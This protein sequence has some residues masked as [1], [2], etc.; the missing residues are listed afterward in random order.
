MQDDPR[1]PAPPESSVQ[2]SVP[3]SSEG[4]D[5]PFARIVGVLFS[6]EE[7]FASIARRPDWLVPLLLMII[8]AVGS[9]AVLAPKIDYEPQF[10]AM[11]ENNRN[12]PPEQREKL[13]EESLGRVE[14]MKVFGYVTPV[15]SILVITLVMAGVFWGGLRAFGGDNSFKQTYAVTVYGWIPMFLKSVI[16]TLIA[17]P[18][19]VIDARDLGS[20]LKSNLGAFVDSS[21]AP[22]LNSLL[23]S[24]DLFNIWTIVL[25]TIGLAAI[26]RFNRTNLA[27]YVTALYLIVV[28][29]KVGFAALI[30]GMG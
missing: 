15:L 29:V 2:P 17:L 16:S 30:G 25:F 27:I 3:S 9:F 10:R 19:S 4:Q 8:V 6:P 26:S 11:F 12:I 24:V 7:T 28:A 20:L 1:A 22:V 18:R 13:I 14:A 5:N 21:E 23:S